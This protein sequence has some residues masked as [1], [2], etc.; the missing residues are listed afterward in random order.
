MPLTTRPTLSLANPIPTHNNN[1]ST[2]NSSREAHPKLTNPGVYKAFYHPLPRPGP[3]HLFANHDA[4]GLLQQRGRQTIRQQP[5]LPPAILLTGAALP[6]LARAHD[7]ARRADAD[8]DGEGA[9]ER[10]QPAEKAHR[11]GSRSFSSVSLLF[12]L[13]LGCGVCLD[14]FFVLCVSAGFT[15]LWK[16]KSVCAGYF[17][18]K[19][20]IETNTLKCMRCR[21]RKIR[22]SGDPGQGMPCNNCKNAGSEQCRFLRV[23]P[24]THPPPLGTPQQSPNNR[25]RSPP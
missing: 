22:C 8:H 10:V 15:S 7:R 25:K 18:G 21:K 12:P 16:G 13:L 5:Q 23:S 1:G 4:P 19:D 3:V 6:P 20:S 24:P 9:R 17:F 14:V 11:R 2:S